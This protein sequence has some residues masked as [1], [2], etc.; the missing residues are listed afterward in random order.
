MMDLHVDLL[1]L[2]LGD[3]VFCTPEFVV[4][5]ILPEVAKFTG[6]TVPAAGMLVTGYALGVVIGAPIMTVLGNR[7]PRKTMLVS[8]M[9]IFVIGNALCAVAPGYP[10]LVVGRVVA[11]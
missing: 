6:V 1:A 8:L 2:A 11:A 5:G 3:F 10:T 4:V 7:L 9:G